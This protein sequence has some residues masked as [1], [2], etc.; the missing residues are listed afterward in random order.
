MPGI[1]LPF[2]SLAEGLLVVVVLIV[3]VRGRRMANYVIDAVAQ[4]LIKS[5]N[6]GLGLDGIRDDIAHMKRQV[7]EVGVLRTQVENLEGQIE[8]LLTEENQ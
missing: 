3:L 8:V 1:D 6:G 5:I 2:D 7:G 4:A